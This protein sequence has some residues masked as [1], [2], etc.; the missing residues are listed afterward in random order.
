MF[1]IGDIPVGAS[2]PFPFDTYDSDGASITI[3]GL[4]VT[5]IE[6]YKDGSTT[7]RASDNGYTLLDTDGIDFDGATGLHGFSVDFSDNSD[8]GFYASGSYYWVHVNA[9]TVDGQ[10]VRFTYFLSIGRNDVNVVQV[11]GD[12]AAADN[13][14]SDYDGTGYAKA[15]STIGTTT[16]NTDMRGTDSA[17]LAANVPTNF[18]SLAINVSGHVSRVTLCDTTTTNSDMRGTDSASTHTAADVWSS[19]TRELTTGAY[20]AIADQV[21]E[22]AIADHVD[23]NTFGGQVQGGLTSE[24]DNVAAGVWDEATA[25]H[26]LVGSFGKLAA[27]IT[28]PSG[29]PGATPTPIEALGVLYAIAV[30]K[31]DFNKT[32]GKKTFYNSSDVAQWEKDA[33]DDGTTYAETKGNAV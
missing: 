32:T 15:N 13:L 25:D 2:V 20:N 5:D 19:G 26:T 8:A 1:V 23:L 12:S 27:A 7:Q 24:I 16:T 30:Q 11:S 6:I 17:L 28:E 18:A 9:I 3:T 14:E 33:T 22:E 29:V 21:W 31:A 4:A 10:T